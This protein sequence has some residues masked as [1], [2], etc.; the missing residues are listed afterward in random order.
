MES[1]EDI[2]IL[3]ESA[4]GSYYYPI[5]ADDGLTSSVINGFNNDT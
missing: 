1:S 2:Q 5:R 3:Y 4:P